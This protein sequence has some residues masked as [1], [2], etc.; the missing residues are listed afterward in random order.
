[1]L[2]RTQA[3]Q[4]ARALLAFEATHLK[5]RFKFMNQRDDVLSPVLNTATFSRL[6]ADPHQCTDGSFATICRGIQARMSPTRDR[7]LGVLRD[8]P[9]DTNNRS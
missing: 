9:D 8:Q 5:G 3:H 7:S 4:Q 1:M 6:L 2:H